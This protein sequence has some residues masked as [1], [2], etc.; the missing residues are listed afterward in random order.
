MDAYITSNW[1]ILEMFRPASE[2]EVKDIIITSLNK[3]VNFDPLAPWLLRICV[4]QP[5]R[6]KKGLLGGLWELPGG[7]IE[8]GEK[9]MVIEA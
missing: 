5:L 1:K 9:I 2:V 7:K 3:S 8:K 4:D 6:K